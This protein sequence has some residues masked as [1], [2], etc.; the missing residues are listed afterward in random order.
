MSLKKI[1]IIVI[2]VVLVAAI[3]T[4]AYFA[5]FSKVD[6]ADDTVI[7][8]VGDQ[9]I[10]AY[11]VAYMM[12]SYN[13][14]SQGTVTVDDAIAE[15]AEFKALAQLAKDNNI[16]L[17]D[18]DVKAV[19]NE[20]AEMVSY[21]GGEDV[22]NSMLKQFGINKAQ[23]VEVGKLSKV[24]T[25]LQEKA[26][27]LG[28]VKTPTAD[29]IQTYYNDN[30]LRAK[31]ILFLNTDQDGNPIEDSAVLK[32]A[33]DIYNKIK[34]GDS[35]DKY[36]S[37]SEDPGSVSN[38]NGYL[39]VNTAKAMTDKSDAVAQEMLSSLQQ[40]GLVMVEEF[41]KGTAALEI[42]AV[43]EPVKTSYGYHIIN[44]LDIN[45]TPD[46][47]ESQK[48]TISYIIQGLDYEKMLTVAKEENPVKIRKRTLK[49]LDYYLEAKKADAL[50]AMSSATA[51]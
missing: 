17:T 15:L 32:K 39:F 13:S 8:R 21:Y 27:E 2:A 31:H 14:M 16:E 46:L 11:E 49:S 9:E 36:A 10:Y 7:A 20:V 6:V 41:E 47:F 28:L 50:D 44:R 35:F 23:Y 24:C 40:L 37:L 1:L 29:E 43:S 42:G 25:L 4:G 51:Q 34:A 30:F 33:T 18:L 48:E 38:P 22:F 19:E 45:E 3:A 12:Q 5:F 26:P